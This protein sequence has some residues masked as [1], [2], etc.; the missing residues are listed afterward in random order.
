MTTV[1]KE[2]ARSSVKDRKVT[3]TVS[4]VLQWNSVNPPNIT[5]S[6]IGYAV[7][8]S[9]PTGTA[10][11]NPTTGSID[12]SSMPGSTEYDENID[13]TLLLDTS[14]MLDANGNPLMGADT[15]RWAKADEG[16]IYTDSKGKEQHSGYGWFC[17]ITSWGPPIEYRNLPPIE[18]DKIK[19]KRKSDG[20]LVIDDDSPDGSPPYAF[21][22]AFVLP[23]SNNRYYISID[24]VLSRKGISGNKFMLND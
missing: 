23:G 4:P 16:T 21:K 7:T 19:F 8:S 1:T 13:I 11:V 12:I 15:P 20:E 9:D 3:I 18:I 17:E 24:P 2:E 10:T 6:S 22:F 14:T 5:T